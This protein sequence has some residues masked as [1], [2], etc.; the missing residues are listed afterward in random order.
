M[1]S[2]IARRIL[3]HT[4][5]VVIFF[6]IHPALFLINHKIKMRCKREVCEGVGR[7]QIRVD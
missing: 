1:V 4:H 7:A 6:I 3:Y 5:M 2:S